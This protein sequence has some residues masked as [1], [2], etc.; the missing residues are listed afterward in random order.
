MLVRAVNGR[1]KLDPEIPAGY[2]GH[3][4]LM[5]PTKLTIQNVINDDLSSTTIKVRRSLMEVNDNHMRSFFYLLQNEKDRTPVNYGAKVNGET[6]M[7]I[8]SFVAQKLYKTSF[9]G[10]L[11]EPVSHSREA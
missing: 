5:W 4:I 9:G 1:R 3:S 8:T 6:D 10:V 11:G 7:L 2:M